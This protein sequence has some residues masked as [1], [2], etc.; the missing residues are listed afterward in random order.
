[1]RADAEFWVTLRKLTDSAADNLERNGR[2]VDRDVLFK[3][4][5]RE[6][7]RANK[8]RNKELGNFNG[9]PGG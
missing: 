7:A 4:F 2:P 3:H 9:R 5:K 8:L 1:M 6:L